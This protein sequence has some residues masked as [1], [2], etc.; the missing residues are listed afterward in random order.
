MKPI[1]YIARTLALIVLAGVLVFVSRELLIR[2]VGKTN[3]P[4]DTDRYVVPIKKSILKESLSQI[5]TVSSV[6]DGMKLTLPSSARDKIAADQISA[7]EQSF[8]ISISNEGETL[9]LTMSEGPGSTILVPVPTFVALVDRGII[10]A[11]QK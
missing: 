6:S 4:I 2:N 9:V 3:V 5:G 7:N 11:S 8:G 1:T 10:K